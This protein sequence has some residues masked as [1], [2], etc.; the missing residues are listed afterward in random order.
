MEPRLTCVHA[1]NGVCNHAKLERVAITIEGCAACPH[2]LGPSRGL[3]DM[4]AKVTHAVGIRPCGGCQKRREELNAKF[5][6]T[7]QVP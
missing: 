6:T 4:I 3:G 7:P 2:Y 5:P 1:A